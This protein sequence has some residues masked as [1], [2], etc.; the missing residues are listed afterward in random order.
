MYVV[1]PSKY[2][3]GGSDDVFIMADNARDAERYAQ[4]QF[5][6]EQ[7]PLR[8]FAHKMGDDVIVE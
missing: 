3:E 2:V 7:F 1:C 4:D 5:K 6:E 8:V